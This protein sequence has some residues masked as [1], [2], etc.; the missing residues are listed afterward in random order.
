MESYVSVFR[1]ALPCRFD[2]GDEPR[3]SALCPP[4]ITAI[5]SSNA[6]SIPRP[7][8][9]SGDRGSIPTPTR[10]SPMAPAARRTVR[11]SVSR[12]P[13][14]QARDLRRRPTSPDEGQDENDPREPI[15]HRSPLPH[16]RF[17][18]QR[19]RR[20]RSAAAPSVVC[21]NYTACRR[22]HASRSAHARAATK[23][24]LKSSAA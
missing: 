15:H 12:N 14:Q 21:R 5:R 16:E 7:I 17:S 22:Y 19:R 1:R 20:Q 9:L 8:D 3:H 11:I 6:I 18:H 13:R 4:L 10:P 24:E 23:A 2:T